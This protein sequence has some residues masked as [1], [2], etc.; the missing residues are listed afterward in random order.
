MPLGANLY[1]LHPSRILL[2][3]R[4]LAKFLKDHSSYGGDDVSP[5][6]RPFLFKKEGAARDFPLLIK[7]VV[8]VSKGHVSS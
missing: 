4:T 2:K 6:L 8:Q 5:R 3:E 1:T 7:V